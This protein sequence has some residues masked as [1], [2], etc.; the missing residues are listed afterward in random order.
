MYSYEKKNGAIGRNCGDEQAKVKYFR[1]IRTTRNMAKKKMNEDAFFFDFHSRIMRWTG[2][3]GPLLNEP[4]SR[5]RKF[6]E[7]SELSEPECNL[8]ASESSLG[9]IFL[10]LSLFL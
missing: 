3:A 6:G 7:L 1:E 5:S 2:Q 4:L 9:Y 8:R 10:R